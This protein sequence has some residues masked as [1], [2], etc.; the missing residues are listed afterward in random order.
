[1]LNSVVIGTYMINCPKCQTL[2]DP[3]TKWGYKKFCSRT[4]GNSRGPRSD[5]FKQRNRELALA[6]PKGWALDPKKYNTTSARWAKQR[7]SIECA[8]CKKIFEVAHSART[9]KYCSVA[10]ANK[11]KFHPNS[12]IKHSSIYKGYKMDS[13][14]ELLFA[15]KC[16]ELNI[17]WHKNTTEY[18]VF[19]NS[20][21]KQSKYYPD[22]YLQDYD[23]WV[24]VKGLRYVREDDELRRAAVPKPV[25]L[26]I[27]NNFKLYFDQLLQMLATLRRIELR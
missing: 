24:E 2:F 25:F 12:T 18:Y 11:N 23:I 3:K 15:K 10:C 22:F 26:L 6:N 8:E 19:T 21:N 27:S 4:C 7:K 1:M 16:D 20:K 14:A 13:G 5:E 9:R 17:R